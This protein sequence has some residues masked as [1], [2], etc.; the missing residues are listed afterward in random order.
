MP[1]V[2]K[3]AAE[4]LGTLVKFNPRVETLL[5]ELIVNADVNT[6]KI[7]SREEVPLAVKI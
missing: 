2:R 3:R 6:V 1:E 5:Q 7:I 4:S